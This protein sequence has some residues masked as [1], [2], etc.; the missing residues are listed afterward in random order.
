METISKEMA[1]AFKQKWIEEG[2]PESMLKPCTLFNE[3]EEFQLA[4]FSKNTIHGKFVP[5]KEPCVWCEI[6]IGILA[7]SGNYLP[8]DKI[9]CHR[10]GRKVK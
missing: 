10:C 7:P 1:D 2:Y 8:V 4:P 5:D 9:Y 6:T 3:L